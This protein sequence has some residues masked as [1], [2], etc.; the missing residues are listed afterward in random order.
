MVHPLSSPGTMEL[1]TPMLR[2]WWESQFTTGPTTGQRLAWPAILEGQHTLLCAPTGT[3]KTLAAL[4]P[5]YQELTARREPHLPGIKCLYLAPLKALCNDLHVRIQRD[6]QQLVEF[7]G[8]KLTVGLR[9]GDVAHKERQRLLDDPPD[10]LISTPESLS[11]LLTHAEADKLLS[12]IRWVIIDEVHAL[13]CNKRGADLTVS[14]ERLDRLCPQPPQRIGL[15]AT[16]S[17]LEEVARWLGGAKHQVSVL[18]VPDRT[19]WELSIID[20]TQASKES[21]FLPT[22]LERLQHLI[23]QN[24]TLLVFTNVRSLAERI[25]WS[26]RRRLP[27]LADQIA[28]H[29]GSIARSTRHHVEGQLQRGEL[30]V[31]ISSTSLELGIDIGYIDHVAFIHAP[32]GAARLLQRVGR[33]G[34]RPDGKRQGTLFV[35]SHIELLEAVTTKAAAEDGFLEPMQLPQCPLDVL[36]QQLVAMAVAGYY[37][38]RAAW[39]LLHESYPFRHLSLD[40]FARC[41]EYLTGGNSQIDVPPRVKIIDHC[42]TPASPIIPRLFRTNAG[43]IQ[44]EP[45]RMVYIEEGKTSSPEKNRSLGSVPNHFADRLLPGDRFLLTGRVYELVRHERSAI[46]VK[47]SSGLPAFTRWRGGTMNM[48]PILATRLWTLRARLHDALIE[49]KEAAQRLLQHEYAVSEEP[50]RAL[51]SW[52]QRQLEVSEI[53]DQGLL[54]EACA[55]PH[56]EYVHYA[57]HIPLAAPACEGLARVLSWRLHPANNF[58]LEPGP[59][60]FLITLQ[61]EDE[62]TPERLRILLSPDDYELDLQRVIVHGPALGRRFMEAAHTGLML[63]R[64]PLRGRHRRVGGSQWAGDKLMHWLRFAAGNF[65]L[66]Q[67]AQREACDDYYQAQSAHDFLERLQWEEIRLRWIAEPSPLAAEWL[68][69][70]STAPETNLTSLDELLLALGTSQQEAIHVAPG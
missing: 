59:L 30:R 27:H 47:E 51:T 58:P 62:L 33:G 65:P 29:H 68:P 22:M 66:L 42:L 44:D 37:S 36:C 18:R 40:D 17:P 69:H 32:G 50:A 26:L 60:G 6:A 13:A 67:Q 46:V 11:L 48:S 10:I 61:A 39:N 23:D 35:G 16:C 9:T 38:V 34:H 5:M 4:V 45:H 64:T 57:F 14:L 49:S 54:V 12:H 8:H 19:Q 21:A 25:S 24:R 56:G 55:S 1:V 53:P 70:F 15:S 20:L 63:L 2:R 3:G 31:V 43:T 7:T 41:L 28:V 52:L